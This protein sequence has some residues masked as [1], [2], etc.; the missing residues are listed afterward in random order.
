MRIKILGCGASAGVP[1]MG[2]DCAVCTSDNPK[3]VRSR[4]SVHIEAQGQRL[5]I[6]TGPDLRAQ[7]LRHG[8]TQVDAI[9][10]THDHADHT[11]GIDDV[12]SFNFAANKALPAYADNATWASLQQRFGY[13]FKPPITQ[14][15]WFKPSL[16]PVEIEPFIPFD[17]GPVSIFPFAQTHGRI[18]SMG[19]RIGDFAY[20]TDVNAMSE[21]S[22]E[23]LQGLDVWVV[24]CLRYTPSPT[25]A[26]LEQTL[27][28]ITAVKPKRA[29][30]THMSHEFDYDK[31]SAELPVNVE[32]GYDGLE[33]T[34]DD[35]QTVA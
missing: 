28:W 4:V 14:Y 27:Q 12:R 18:H 10:Y 8:I 25:H 21:A 23:A 33:I 29:I 32:P 11:H 16:E 22:L 5:L 31:L 9:L 1:V 19:F 7:A 24:D 26:H 15:G 13:A 6:D 17:I 30:L 2:C 34:L 20:S 3:N 35:L